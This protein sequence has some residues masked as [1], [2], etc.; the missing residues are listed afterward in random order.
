MLPPS[1][2]KSVSELNLIR[3][4]DFCEHYANAAR[5]AARQQQA[6]PAELTTQW[7]RG[8]PGAGAATQQT[9]FIT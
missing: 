9:S 2:A 7:W 6:F 4:Q 3:Q 5:R 1:S 8:W